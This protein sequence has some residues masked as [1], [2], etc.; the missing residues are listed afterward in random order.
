MISYHANTIP[1]TNRKGL[2]CSQVI[3]SVPL[4][5]K[6]ALGVEFQWVFEVAR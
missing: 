3:V 4:V 5:A 6:E 2:Q 1:W